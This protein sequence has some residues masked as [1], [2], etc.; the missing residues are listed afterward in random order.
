MGPHLV[1]RFLIAFVVLFGITAVNFTFITVS[2][3]G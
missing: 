3:G 1:R 2:S